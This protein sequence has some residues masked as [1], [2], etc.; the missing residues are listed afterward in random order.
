MKIKMSPMR[1]HSWS[2]SCLSTLCMECTL[3]PSRDTLPPPP[4]IPTLQGVHLPCRNWR[5][6]KYSLHTNNITINGI[7]LNHC[8]VVMSWFRYI[9]TPLKCPYKWDLVATTNF[10]HLPF[11]LNT[12]MPSDMQCFYIW[13]GTALDTHCHLAT[14][15]YCQNCGN[16]IS[17]Y[18]HILIY[19]L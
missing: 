9:R 11:L 5:E 7:Y 4:C 3:Q 16:G 19:S 17:Y 13:F 2:V 8:E 1:C 14:L 6:Q 10:P 12:Y 18:M 15:P